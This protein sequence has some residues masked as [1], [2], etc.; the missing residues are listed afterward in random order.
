MAGRDVASGVA[1]LAVAPVPTGAWNLLA[2]SVIMMSF[3]RREVG[4]E[5][6]Y[7]RGSFPFVL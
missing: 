3:G 6:R 4:N 5:T 2:A 7:Q 1:W